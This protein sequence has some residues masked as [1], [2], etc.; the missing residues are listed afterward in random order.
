MP[1]LAHRRV[2]ALKRA[3]PPQHAQPRT[4]VQAPKDPCPHACRWRVACNPP[5]AWGL[6]GGGTA[7]SRVQQ[8]VH[9]HAR[10]GAGK[11]RGVGKH[12]E[13][14]GSG[15]CSSPCVQQSGLS[16]RQRKPRCTLCGGSP[17][18]GMLGPGG[19]IPG[20]A[21]SRGGAEWRKTASELGWLRG[22]S[23]TPREEP[24]GGR[25]THD[26]MCTKTQSYSVLFVAAL[27][28]AS[29]VHFKA[30]AAHR[31]EATPSVRRTHDS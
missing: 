28:S 30:P 16:G 18:Q 31:G 8:S 29:G 22:A 5:H 6:A 14:T 23:C 19:S 27:L 7:L 15:V 10:V 9:A 2:A 4:H 3:T 17:T 21:R 12:A 24:L 26:S 13:N 11:A 25:R 20:R 1:G